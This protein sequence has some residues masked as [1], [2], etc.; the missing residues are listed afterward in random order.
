MRKFYLIPLAM[1]LFIA[2]VC[3]QQINS[4]TP[5]LSA[6]RTAANT[7]IETRHHQD[8]HREVLWMEDFSSGLSSDNGNWT[9]EG[10][11]LWQYVTEVANGCWSA[12]GDDAVQ[13]TS[14]NNGF[15]IYHS[16]EANCIDPDQNPPLETENSYQGALISPSIDL[17]EEEAVLVTFEQRFRY[18]CDDDFELWFSVS[19][20]G[21]D[22]WTDID[23]TSGTP[24]GDYNEN[25]ITSLNISQIAENESDVR[26]RFLWNA[27]NTAS[28]YFWAIDDITVEIPEAHDMVLIGHSYQQFDPATAFDYVNVKHTIYHVDQVRPL[29]LQA[30]A[31]NKGALIQENVVLHV[32]I[33]TPGGP[34]NLTS[35]PQ[36]VAVGDTAIFNIPY[37]P[38]NETGTYEIMHEIVLENPD[39]FPDNNT[40]NDEFEVDENYFARDE[41][42]REGAFNNY[43]D[44]LRTGLGFTLTEDAVIY[45]IAIALDQTSD[46]GA[47]FRGEL[48]GSDYTLIESTNQAMVEFDM[49]NADGE[50]KFVQLPL[51]SPVSASAGSSFFP[52]FR[53]SGGADVANVAL[54]GYCP[55][56]TCMAWAVTA[57]NG[58]TCNPCYYNSTPM[59]RLLFAEDVGLHTMNSDPD[60]T[61]GQNVPNPAHDF[62][63]IEF[64]FKLRA[65][66]V[67]FE[68]HDQTGRLILRKNLGSL[69]SGKY[70]EVINLRN[71]SPGMYTYTMNVNGH[72]YS[73]KMVVR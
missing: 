41:R 18:C 10:D 68:I 20:D 71:Y 59:I 63:T 66:D 53:F 42:A 54:S 37:T 70:S 67:S 51:Q 69:P 64:E 47:A 19:V 44:T 38:D 14:K 33:N 3:S 35:P 28:H 62:T 4:T 31:V 16:D 36:T 11:N 45:G 27:T 21:G 24:I 12:S 1:G 22:T 58:E 46:V 55:D 2:P 17:S 72:R 56:F 39:D 34:V 57:S 60:I 13:F 5:K 65:S 73:K 50:E 8:N 52:A 9:T 23:I 43:V 49:L 48:L 26:F 6:E 40:A 25:T 7:I 30:L 61:L 15:M 32:S 29:N